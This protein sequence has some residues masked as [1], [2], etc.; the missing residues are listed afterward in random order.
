[1][2]SLDKDVALAFVSRT[3]LSIQYFSSAFLK[4][5]KAS[6][7]AA[8]DRHPYLPM[9]AGLTAVMMNSEPICNTGDLMTIT[10]IQGG[11]IFSSSAK[12]RGR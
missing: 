1:M 5:V 6:D 7:T 11:Q 8:H 12:V 4:Q 10:R 9:V 3:M 2:L